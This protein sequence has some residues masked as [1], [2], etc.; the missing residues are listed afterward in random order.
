M[1]K[2]ITVPDIGSNPVKLQVNGES[3]ELWV[4]KTYVMPD[5]VAEMLEMEVKRRTGK[6]P[7]EDV[8]RLAILED[9]LTRGGSGGGD[10]PEL[11]RVLTATLGEPDTDA[12]SVPEGW[13]VWFLD[14][15]DSGV[16][17]DPDAAAAVLEGGAPVYLGDREHAMTRDSVTGSY[18]FNAE[19]EGGVVS[20]VEEGSDG[21]AVVIR[22]DLVTLLSTAAL[23]GEE[24][25]LLTDMSGAEP[26][27]YTGPLMGH[28]TGTETTGI[29]ESDIT[30]QEVVEAVLD[31]TF[32]YLIDGLHVLI[33]T[34][35]S[36]A[37]NNYSAEL[38]T[39]HGTRIFT[40]VSG[41]TDKWELVSG[42]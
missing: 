11:T 33:P 42:S 29:V 4:G 3:F 8:K 40:S 17:V 13:H 20:R 7:E 14:L 28:L 18:L 6:K 2:T 38:S 24:L 27:T 25:V 5:S 41:E 19:I 21:F 36:A 34:L 10:E 9:V 15:T 39:V 30:V 26:E 31:G 32:C 23:T 1:S 37:N 16:T 35:V 22:S 12:E